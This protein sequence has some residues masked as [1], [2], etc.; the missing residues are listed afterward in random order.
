ML[1][2]G[3]GFGVG[4]RGVV[5]WAVG[6]APAKESAS[7]CTSFFETTLQRSTL[8]F[9]PNYIGIV[10][11]VFSEKALAI[12]R[13]RQKC[14]RNVSKMRQNG[15]R[16][17]GK[18]GTFQDASEMRQKLRQK[19]VKNARNTFGGE[20]LLNDTDYNVPSNCHPV[21]TQMGRYPLPFV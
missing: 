12:A 19:C 17:I 14:V 7:Q 21:A 13:M 10:Q 20:H 3:E 6:W 11:T 18:R 8:E 2:L 5:G 1:S 9:L 4:F 16:F 15:S